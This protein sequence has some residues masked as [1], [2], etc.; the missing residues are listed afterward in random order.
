MRWPSEPPLSALQYYRFEH[1]DDFFVFNTGRRRKSGEL[2]IGAMFDDEAYSAF[3]F[4]SF[5][6][7]IA[8]LVE[9]LITEP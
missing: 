8:E 2:E 4:K 5:D 1:G 6:K 7:H 3:N 9:R